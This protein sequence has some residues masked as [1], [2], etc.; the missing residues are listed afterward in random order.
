MIPIV[1]RIGLREVR[2][3]GWWGQDPLTVGESLLSGFRGRMIFRWS[4]RVP[5]VESA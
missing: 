3:S 4:T 1:C 5:S 2:E